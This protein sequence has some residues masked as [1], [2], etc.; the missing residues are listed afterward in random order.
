MFQLD[1]FFSDQLGRRIV[2][3]RLPLR[4][5]QAKA[6]ED[7]ARFR[8]RIMYRIEFIFAEATHRC[9]G[10]DLIHAV[11]ATHFLDEIRLAFQIHPPARDAKR[12]TDFITRYRLKPK[13]FQILHRFR[14][15]NTDAQ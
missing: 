11:H 9:G 2:D 13:A 1:Q 7:V 6:G 3:Q 12:R 10:G 15:L 14:R 4:L 5:I 8:Q